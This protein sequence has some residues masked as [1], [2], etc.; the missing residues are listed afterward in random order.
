MII[1]E[2]KLVLGRTLRLGPKVKEFDA[3][4][5]L[6]GSIPEFDSM[7]VVNVILA[8]EEQFGIAVADDEITA[9]IFETV[10]SLARFVVSKL[11]A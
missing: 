1:E 4:T 11:P 7:A 5:G 3:G 9:E 6:F 10:G 8:L 2:V